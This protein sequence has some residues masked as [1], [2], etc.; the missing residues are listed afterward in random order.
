MRFEELSYYMNI[1]MNLGTGKNNVTY[2]HQPTTIKILLENDGRAEKRT[3]AEAIKETNNSSK[4]IDKKHY[5]Y[6]LLKDKKI[7]TTKNNIVELADYNHY[8]IKQKTILIELCSAHINRSN[9]DMFK[10][11]AHQ[12]NYWFNNIDVVSVNSFML[13]N[14]KTVNNLLRTFIRDQSQN[15]NYDSIRKILLP[16]ASKT[17]TFYSLNNFKSIFFKLI[18]NY[19]NAGGVIKFIEIYKKKS[20]K[21]MYLDS[22]ISKFLFYIDDRLPII[23]DKID[24][25]YDDIISSLK[26]HISIPNSIDKYIEIIAALNTLLKNLK[27]SK[28]KNN[29]ELQIFCYW[30][31]ALR[32]KERPLQYDLS[33]L[34]LPDFT[35]NS[36][37]LNPYGQKQKNNLFTSKDNLPIISKKKLNNEIMNIQNKILIDKKIIE[38]IVYNILSGKHILLTG[39]IGAGKTHLAQLIPGIWKNNNLGYDAKIYTGTADWNTADVI[40]G[41]EPR[42]VEKKPIYEI[43]YGCVVETILKNYEP[44]RKTRI[45][46]NEY[47]GTWLIIDEFNRANIDKAFGSLFTSL[48]TRLLPIPVQSTTKLE[49]IIIPKDYRIIGTLNTSDKHY[50]HDMSYAMKRRFAII[51][52]TTPDKTKYKEEVYYAL[53]SAINDLKEFDFTDIINFNK[54][55]ILAKKSDKQLVDLIWNVQYIFMFIRLFRNLGTG[56]LKSIYKLLLVSYQM[57][58]N[59]SNLLDNALIVNIIPLLKHVQPEIIQIIHEYCF[60]DLNQYFEKIHN[61]NDHVECMKHAKYFSIYLEFLNVK[62][63]NIN[64]NF[65]KRKIKNWNELQNTEYENIKPKIPMPLF[66]KALLDLMGNGHE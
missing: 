36:Q 45:P 59:K 37:T 35:H 29:R 10:S 55:E 58:E 30:Y 33:E 46:K 44:D 14:E 66:K 32:E 28:I 40:S 5:V 57:S 38:N 3:I 2:F 56:I 61:K 31:V 27:G 15:S 64:E 63:N 18:Y 39:P 24:K 8:S 34:N 51:E 11:L 7:I 4:Y 48:E 13:K 20:L 21:N 62:K 9:H 54:R 25:V 49:E 65:I 60:N 6:D 26:L 41:I 19:Y 47:N 17:I 22:D 12:F 1:D 50:L 43:K 53:Y 23:D 42:T 52:I 16:K